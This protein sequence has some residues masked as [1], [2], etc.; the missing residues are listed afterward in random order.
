MQPDN[1]TE[2]SKVRME[3]ALDRVLAAKLL[4]SDELYIDAT[5]R[6]YYAIFYAMRAVLALDGVDRKH[7]SAVISEFRK[8]YTKTGIFSRDISDIITR[9]FDARTGSDYDDYYVIVKEDVIQQVQDAEY[10]VGVVKAYL[11]RILPSE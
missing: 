7:H 2:L 10:F 8:R 5:N 6:S 11:E 9:L 3:Y 1:R 4:L